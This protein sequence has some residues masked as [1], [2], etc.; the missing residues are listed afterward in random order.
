MIFDEDVRWEMLR[1]EEFLVRQQAMPVVYLPMGLCEPH[2][3]VAPF[4]LDTIK[5]DWL[6]DRAARRFGGIVAPTMA[7]HTHETGYHAPW[8][9]EVMGE[10]NP[11]LCALPPHL[12]LETLLYQLRAFHNAG[13]R[14]AV[15]IS[16]HHG[17]QEDLR[18]VSRTFEQ[19]F[20]FE[21]FV[22][23][24]PELVA[25]SYPG[26]HAGRYEL[27]QLLAIRSDLVAMDRA[28]RIRSSFLGRFA[29]NPDVSDADIAY[30]TEI[31]TA[32]ID[33]IG[34]AVLT[35]E[36]APGAQ[37]QIGMAEMGPLWEEI[38]AERASWATLND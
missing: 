2:G 30:G 33:A 12:V 20:R 1:P 21:T 6:C 14:A 11:R 36:L 17:S 7:Y 37:D 25:G 27:S 38:Y 34:K 26:D 3:H 10:V 24:D 19:R 28:S 8:L 9:R 23:T 4:G 29:Q 18:R 15:V 22:R 13:F 35:F 5:A 16:G 31:L 32:Q